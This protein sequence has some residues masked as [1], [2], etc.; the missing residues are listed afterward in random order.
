MNRGIEDIVD[1]CVDLMQEG[2]TLEQCLL[3]YPEVADD[4]EPLLRVAYDLGQLPK[5][6]PRQ[7]ALDAAVAAAGAASTRKSQ[8][9][10]FQR[11]ADNSEAPRS[12]AGVVAF[13]WLTAAAAVLV[14]TIGLSTA[15]ARSLPGDLLYTLKLATERVA[16]VLTT[17][18][19]RR[20]EL[21][22]SFAD[23]RLEE[24]VRTAQADGRI[25][26]DLLKRLLNEATLALEDS[27]PVSG[28][29]YQEIVTRVDAF[30]TYQRQV[31][32]QLQPVVREDDAEL[33]TR[34][35]SVCDER[36]RWMRRRWGGG[37]EVAPTNESE[38]TAIQ[39]QEQRREQDRCWD[40]GCRW[41]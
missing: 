23:N 9:R 5:L 18:P 10:R 1:R 28:D 39:P 29:R 36:D 24:L 34:A 21:R 33:L 16:F 20:A 27:K 4:I 15:S 38:G 14:L 35:I 22:L 3:L 37:R 6:E 7:V 41:D 11:V 12:R 40:S 25:D 2:R 17:G 8:R 26:P 31:F 19:D 32:E 30:N 13:R